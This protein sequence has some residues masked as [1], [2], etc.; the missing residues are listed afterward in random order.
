MGQVYS[1]LGQVRETLGA[2]VSRT[3]P[4]ILIFFLL[5]GCRPGTHISKETSTEPAYD[6][7]FIESSIGD[8]SYL[9]P[10]LASDSASSAINGMVFNGLVKYG[11]Q[12][13]L[14]GDLAEKWEVS[15]DGLTILFTLRKN[16]LW[17]DGQPF[18]AEDVQYTFERLLDP[19]VKTPYSSNYEKVK[20]FEVLDPYKIKVTYVEPFVPA[21]ES[22]GMGIVPKHI[23]KGAKG[24]QFN[25]HPANKKPVGTGPYIFKEW[26][27]DEKVVLRANPNYF[28]GKPHINRYI[29]RIIPDN[30]VE[31]LELRNKSIDT[32][33]LTPDQYQAYP[34][35]FEGYKKYRFPRAAYTYIGFNLK[36]PLFKEK[37][38][39]EALAHAINKKEMVEGVLLGMGISATGPFLPSS[40]AYDPNVKDFEYD[41]NLAKQ[42]LEE[43]GWKDT[44]GDGL[45]D[46][47]GSKF[48][49]TLMTNQG[50]KMRALTA[51]ILQD[52][53]KKV[54][55]KM[56]I[57]I[58]EWST[59]IKNFID[60][61]NFEAI[62]LGWSLSPDPD[63]YNIWHSSQKK[64]GQYNFV[65]YEN[66][67]V[68]HLLEEGR[69]TFDLNRRKEI[70]QKIHKIVQADIPYIFLYYP[71]FLP[72]VH[73]R[74][75][76]P[77]VV[78]LSSFGF[79]WNFDKWYVPKNLVRY[80]VMAQE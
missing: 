74:F 9:N 77:E 1:I 44:T 57:R 6:D 7:S 27:T 58:I 12:I 42:I 61:R 39:R 40:W 48:E 71:E 80:P 30:S 28:E 64:D 50:N 19:E 76:G 52:Q 22:W 17:H 51:E 62:I 29:F 45:L 43:L 8:A 66:L 4:K 18:T 36:H 5:L 13:E 53:L 49:F 78:P 63:I 73:E 70:Y 16:V 79:G 3:C 59:F 56:N 31:F 47:N 14:V 25:E 11:P 60:K 32:M 69:R 21:L 72:V 34:E 2:N 26:R 33:V 41:P 23:F 54:G 10:I 68:D 24:S 65:S 55:I 20:S 37:K 67:E 38:V 15:K 75:V 35:F 46:K